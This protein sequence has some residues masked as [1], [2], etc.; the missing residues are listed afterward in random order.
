MTI[1]QIEVNG[2]E[3]PILHYKFAIFQPNVVIKKEHNT[4]FA[5]IDG[6]EYVLGASSINGNHAEIAKILDNELLYQE[7]QEEIDEEIS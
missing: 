1:M 3:Y 2:K 6:I 7:F 5:E 4:Y